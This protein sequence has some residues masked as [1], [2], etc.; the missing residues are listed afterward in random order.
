MGKRT[1][2]IILCTVISICLFTSLCLAQEEGK[3]VKP[4]EFKIRGQL[5]PHPETKDVKVMTEDFQS[6]TMPLDKGVRIEVTTRGKLED[7]ATVLPTRREL[8]DLE[9][10]PGD[11]I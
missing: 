8:S 9:I 10:R 3:K 5:I 11:G 2:I 7:M 6:F 4:I 1:L